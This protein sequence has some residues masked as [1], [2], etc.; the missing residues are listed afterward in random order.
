MLK[1][2]CSEIRKKPKILHKKHDSFFKNKK[3]KV[4]PFRLA[5]WCLVSVKDAL[6]YLVYRMSTL[7]YLLVKFTKI[8]VQQLFLTNVAFS[9]LYWL[10]LKYQIYKRNNLK[11]Y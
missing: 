10:Y 11:K 7:V 8:G 3:N 6:L 2:G 5:V 1:P 9:V 4:L